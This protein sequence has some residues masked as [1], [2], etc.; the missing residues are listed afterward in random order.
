VPATNSSPGRILVIEDDPRLASLVSEYLGEA[1]YRVTVAETGAAGL[2]RAARETFDALVLDLMLPD[3]DGLDVCCKLRADWALPI[4][5]L[6]ARGD[7]MDRDEVA[8]LAISFNSAATRIEEPINAHT[9][10][11]ANRLVCPCQR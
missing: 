9:M 6:T 8:R 10:L 7:A 5:M 1:G 3:M 2:N 11:L 4:L